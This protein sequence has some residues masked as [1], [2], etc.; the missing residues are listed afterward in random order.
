MHET[1]VQKAA[2]G[3]TEE[4][5]PARGDLHKMRS[6]MAERSCN[7]EDVCSITRWLISFLSIT[8]FHKGF[9]SRGNNNCNLHN[10]NFAFNLKMINSFFS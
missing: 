10:L 3:Q 8:R 2:S 4:H 6:S 1:M 9:S 7:T 5:K